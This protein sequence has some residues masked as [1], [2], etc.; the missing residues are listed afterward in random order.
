VVISDIG[1]AGGNLLVKALRAAGRDAQLP[2]PV[3]PLALLATVARM[4]QP[5]GA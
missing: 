5:V 3:E 1:L 2:R 4:M